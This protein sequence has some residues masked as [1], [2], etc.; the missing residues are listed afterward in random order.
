MYTVLQHRCLAA[1]YCA[2]LDGDFGEI[3]RR[4][5]SIAI[6]FLHVH[7][8]YPMREEGEERGREGRGGKREG[9]EGR[10]GKREGR[11]GR[12]ERGRGKERK[13]ERGKERM[14]EG[15]REKGEDWLR[16][17]YRSKDGGRRERRELISHWLQ[18]WFSSSLSANLGVSEGLVARG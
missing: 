12:E 16:R 11:E 18:P 9:R 8:F 7:S 6:V 10:G 4:C 5:P 15:K 17:M 3:C 13:T 14:M 1:F 2:Q